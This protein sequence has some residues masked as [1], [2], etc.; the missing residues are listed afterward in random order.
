[1]KTRISGRWGRPTPIRIIGAALALAIPGFIVG[2]S[3]V[4]AEPG[5]HT[6]PHPKATLPPPPQIRA[7]ESILLGTW[8]CVESN[9]PPGR[10][11]TTI[12]TTS[13][14]ALDG[15]YYYSDVTSQA[16][17]LHG[18]A[19]WGWNPVEQVFFRQYHDNWGSYSTSE[20]PTWKDGHLI[21]AG[22]FMAVS[23]PD[24]TGHAKGV[25]MKLVDDY[26]LVRPGYYKL[27]STVATPDGTPYRHDANCTRT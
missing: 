18:G 24:P 10:E 5:H 8:K 1:M 25:R 17:N 26:M 6:K 12:T 16:G 11:P 23:S 13:K 3:P 4:S 15:H 2:A 20:S 27:V 7:L 19:A 9:P 14:R 22:E 21:F